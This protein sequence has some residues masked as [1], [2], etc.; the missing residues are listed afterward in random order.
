MTDEQYEQ[1][2]DFEKK[3]SEILDTISAL[4]LS[5]DW[6]DRGAGSYLTLKT[7]EVRRILVAAKSLK[8]D[9]G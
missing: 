7:S 6:L 1:R 8:E 9:L 5:L 4:N 3:V 2:I